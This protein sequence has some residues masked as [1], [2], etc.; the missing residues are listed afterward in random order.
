M[1]TIPDVNPRL[2]SGTL[3][4]LMNF[5]NKAFVRTWKLQY[6]KDDF[7]FLFINNHLVR[8]QE[9]CIKNFKFLPIQEVLHLLTVLDASLK[10]AKMTFLI[11]ERIIFIFFILIII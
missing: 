4:V 6:T 5:K 9:S 10:E 3:K 1:E 2:L 8:P 7:D 11:P